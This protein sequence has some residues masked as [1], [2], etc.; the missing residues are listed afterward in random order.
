MIEIIINSP[1]KNNAIAGPIEKSNLYA[2]SRPPS[3]AI[4]A[5]N[6]LSGLFCIYKLI[7]RKFNIITSD[8]L[9]VVLLHGAKQDQY[10]YIP[11]LLDVARNAPAISV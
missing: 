2:N 9:A 6:N 10:S 11:C 1:P 7:L 5:A 4:I 8:Q 3:E